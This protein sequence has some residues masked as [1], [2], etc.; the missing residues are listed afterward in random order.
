MSRLEALRARYS[1]PDS[2]FVELGGVPVHYLDEGT[3]PPIVLVHGSFLD[4]SAWDAWMPALAGRRVIRFDR[5]RYGL[6]GLAPDTTAIDYADEEALLEALV[7]HLGLGRFSLAGSSSGG[8]MAADYAAANPERVERLVLVNFPLG[9]ARINNSAAEA[10]TG[11]GR[12]RMRQLL[13]RNFADPALV[14]TDVVDRLADLADRPDPTGA[15]AT[16]WKRAAAF[17]EADRAAVLGRLSMPTLVLWSAENRTL[18]VEHGRAAFDAVGAAQKWFTVVE[19]VGHMLPLE[20][21]EV[22]GEVV[23]RFLDGA[24]VPALVKG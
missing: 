15:I 12:A 24:A 6:S 20:G 7:D 19:N 1:R 4:L 9:H 10:P 23:R 21:G 8:M 16:A 5:L 18:T 3:G 22:S 14:T 17:S 2:R 11:D 13:E